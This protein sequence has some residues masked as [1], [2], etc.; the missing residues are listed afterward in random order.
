M[1]TFVRILGGTA[2]QEQNTQSLGQRHNDRDVCVKVRSRSYGSF[3][4]GGKLVPAVIAANRLTGSN[5]IMTPKPIRH[6]QDKI[7]QK[8]INTH[9]KTRLRSYTTKDYLT[10][11]DYPQ[12]EDSA[13]VSA[14]QAHPYSALRRITT[15]PPYQKYQRWPPPH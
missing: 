7:S 3:P 13:L 8:Y 14:T 12:L 1:V 9:Q 5:E 11:P 6:Q 4:R 15:R 2:R 10:L